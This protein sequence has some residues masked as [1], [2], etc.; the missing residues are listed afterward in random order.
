MKKILAMAALAAL[1]AGASVYAANPFSDVSTSDWAYQAVSD[2]S[3][4]GVVEGYP[5]GTFKG[6]N[7]ITRFEMAQIIARLMAK[8]DQLNAEQR[9]TLDKLAGEY[10]GRE[11]RQ[12]GCVGRRCTTR[13]L[14][15][16]VGG[17]G[18]IAIWSS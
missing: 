10:A 15:Q 16:S 7:N 3:D 13:K 12:S 17:Y 9:A 18:A 4:Q 8:E 14:C 5:D 1:A 6:Q 2:L 11:R